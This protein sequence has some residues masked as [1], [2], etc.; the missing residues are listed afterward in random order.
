[1]RALVIG[2]DGFAGRWLTRHLVES[3]DAVWAGVGAHY[4]APLDGAEDVH[5]VDVRD[6]GSVAD[7]VTAARPDHVYDLAGISGR[8]AREDLDA[9]IGVSVIG[10]MNLLL[11]AGRQKHAPR[12]LFVSTGYVYRAADDPV[13]E[14]AAL[15]PGSLYAAAKLAA[16][17]ALFSV[18]PL[19]GVEVVVARPFNHIGPGQR[20]T[21]LVPTLAR[22]VA[23]VA[24]GA[25]SEVEIRDPTIVRDFT[26][27]RDVVR[28]YR[29]LAQRG[30]AG[31]AYNIGSGH[32]VAVADVAATLASIAGTTLRI[33]RSV[34]AER[35]EAPV[36]VGDA[37]KIESLGWGRTHEL[38]TT[39]RDVLKEYVA[40]TAATGG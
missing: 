14:S 31:E 1:M 19:A 35:H 29:L 25:I 15:E 12:L 33:R 30:V 24:A 13:D 38:R 39:L 26:D 10:G 5:Q 22:Q 32:G 7:L 40:A 4:R 8:E 37:R 2:A 28:A 18:S 27:V 21:F 23:E 11:A 16:E 36:L 6:A 17:R 20:G 34:D 9:A 3:G